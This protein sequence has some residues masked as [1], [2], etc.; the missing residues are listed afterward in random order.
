MHGAAGIADLCVRRRRIRSAASLTWPSLRLPLEKSLL[1]PNSRCGTCLQSIRWYDNV[2]L[3]SYLWLRGRCRTC[4]QS[5]SILYFF[6][7]LGTALGFVGL[8][9]L[10][11]VENV[12]GWPGPRPGP[13]SLGTWTS[14]LGFAWH[15]VLFSF[16]VVASVC[17][18]QSREIPLQ[19]TLTGTLVGLIGSALLPW[20]FPNALPVALMPIDDSAGGLRL[21]V[22]VPVARLGRP[23]RQLANRAGDRRDRALVGTFLLRSIGFVFST[24]LGKEAPW[25]RGRRPDDDGRRF[26][27]WQIVGVAFFLSVIPAL[28][29]VS[30]RW[31]CAETTRCRSDHRCPLSVMATS[32]AWDPIGKHFRDS[33]L[34]ARFDLGY[35]AVRDHAV[36]DEFFIAAIPRQRGARNMKP[37]LIVDYGMAN[38]RSVQK[39]FEKVGAAAIISDDPTASLTPTSWCCPASAL[40]AMPSPACVKRISSQPITRSHRA[41]SR[42]SASVS[43]CSSCSRRATKTACITGLD[44]FPGEVVRFDDD[45]RSE[46]AAHGLE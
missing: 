1:W 13:F 6:V 3:L 44:L 39:A 37:I 26:L 38:L 42:S 24:G 31:W 25:P 34:R 43:A 18:L 15:A 5:Y 12:H 21:A 41:A 28:F 11:A 16:L 35:R 14:W 46:S 7:E 27:G 22:L 32:L 10:E 17:D 45:S 8:F 36:R 19:L 40:S 33:C 2:P 4:G 9:W 29:L 20:P 30:F 23:R